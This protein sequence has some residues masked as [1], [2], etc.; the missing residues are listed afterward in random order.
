M[1][2]YAY[3]QYDCFKKIDWDPVCVCLYMTSKCHQFLGI[4]LDYCL[5]DMKTEETGEYH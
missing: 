2:I 4:V 5:P 3:G 1:S